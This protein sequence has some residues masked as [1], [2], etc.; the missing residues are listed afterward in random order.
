MNTKNQTHK[1]TP[2]GGQVTSIRRLLLS[3]SG[4]LRELAA[5]LAPSSAHRRRR[6]KVVAAS[7]KAG[8]ANTATKAV[9]SPSASPKRTSDRRW[10]AEQARLAAAELGVGEHPPG[11][12][13]GSRVH[14]FQ[15]VTGAFKA[16]W[17][18]SFSAWVAV[19]GGFPKAHLP[20]PAA[21]VPAWEAAARDP[22]NPYLSIVSRTRAGAG[23]RVIYDWDGGQGDHI[24]IVSR[25][26]G[27]VK[28]FIAV[29]GN[30]G[31]TVSRKTRLFGRSTTFVRLHREGGGT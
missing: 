19:K 12:N 21:W 31:D 8:G 20:K 15:S 27:P 24:G 14:D 18:A 30:A 7:N 28:G 11:S 23:D 29:E 25:N 2:P 9:A 3:I 22:K 26:L 4:V 10:G 6:R 1:A 16:P 13:D 17:C 5:I